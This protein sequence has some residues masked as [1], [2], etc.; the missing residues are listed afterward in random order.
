MGWRETDLGNLSIAIL[1][2][3][4]SDNGDGRRDC[5]IGVKAAERDGS[6]ADQR[7]Q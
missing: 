3:D 7:A 5:Q 2:C 6:P 4:P 1:V